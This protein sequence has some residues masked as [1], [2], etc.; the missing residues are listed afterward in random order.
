MRT[1]NWYTHF[2]HT[3]IITT[4]VLLGLFVSLF[5]I[6]VNVVFWRAYDFLLPRIGV[7]DRPIVP[8]LPDGGMS[9]PTDPDGARVGARAL[10]EL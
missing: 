1:L 7:R 8:W 6:G 5:W 9:E 2:T 3:Y 10:I 4:K